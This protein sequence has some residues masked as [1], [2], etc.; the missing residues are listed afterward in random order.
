MTYRRLPEHIKTC[1][2]CGTN[3]MRTARRC[4]TC[5]YSFTDM[6]VEPDKGARVQSRGRSVLIKLLI[7]LGLFLLIAAVNVLYVLGME[8]RDAA[9]TRAAA[10][11]A[12]ATYLATIYVSPT[13]IPTLTNTP[14]PPTATPLVDIDYVVKPGD[15]CIS[16]ADFYDIYL[17]E[18]LRK[19][20]DLDCTNLQ[21]GITLRIPPPAPTAVP[22]ETPAGPVVP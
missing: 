18:L 17:D 20:R 13:P 1:P 19:N 2:E 3:L 15:S 14:G 8:N 9:K 10:M 16:I 21:L 11:E 12:T 5:G 22:T 4:A 7:F 6:E